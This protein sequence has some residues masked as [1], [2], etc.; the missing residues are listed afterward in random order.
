[1]EQP[2][3]LV[4]SMRCLFQVWEGCRVEVNLYP[5]GGRIGEGKEG[6]GQNQLWPEERGVREEKCGQRGQG[7]RRGSGEQ[8]ESVRKG[9]RNKVKPGRREGWGE[10]VFK[11]WVYFSSPASALT[12]KKFN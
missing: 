7:G 9:I 6:M 4:R 11:T 1:M 12:G 3:G 8:G 10:G 5:L 2:L